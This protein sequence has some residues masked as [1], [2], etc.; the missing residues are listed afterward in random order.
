MSSMRKFGVC[1]RCVA[2]IGVLASLEGC[3]STRNSLSNVPG[4][5]WMASKEPNV[6]DWETDG[7]L[8]TKPTTEATPL[9]ASRSKPK[10]NAP[11]DARTA[12]KKDAR[13]DAIADG[14]DRRASEGK[15]SDAAK[16]TDS[17]VADSGE[18]K[19][20]KYDTGRYDTGRSEAGRSET[21]KSGTEARAVSTGASRGGAVASSPKR[22]FY[23]SE[24][25]DEEGTPER[26]TAASDGSSTDLASGGG[27]EIVEAAS[28][29]AA[30]VAAAE[31]ENSRGYSRFSQRVMPAAGETP[32]RYSTHEDGVPDET[33]AEAARDFASGAADTARGARDELKG[34]LQEGARAAAAVPREIA[35]SA[36][37]TA[38]EAYQKA[39]R[40]AV[41]VQDELE[42]GVEAATNAVKEEVSETRKELSKVGRGA[43]E[44]ADEAITQTARA[45]DQA[46]VSGAKTAEEAAGRAY[47]RF[48]NHFVDS[49]ESAEATAPGESEPV[50]AQQEPAKAETNSAEPAALPVKRSTQPWRPG[51]TGNYSAA[52]ATPASG[53]EAAEG[54]SAVEPAAY[55][56]ASRSRISPSYR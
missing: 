23:G 33:Y 52:Q 3:R 39:G 12:G 25:S 28:G 19:R 10:S 2:A 42:K 24:Y 44:A 43:A 27:K 36:E 22:G 38:R 51:S 55:R 34:Q 29:L 21:G 13:T 20:E 54:D 40:Q 9:V 41:A 26:K 6:S 14:A 31:A 15:A 1:L 7:A 50:K 48:R 53:Q 5:G 18:A 30:G 49:D 16:R 47:S 46:V 4:M 56:D 32:G 8:P 45:A 17:Q 11:S 37:E 35:E